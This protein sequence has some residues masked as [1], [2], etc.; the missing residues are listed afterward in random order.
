VPAPAPALDPGYRIDQLG[1]GMP[2]GPED[3]IAMWERERVVHP[4]ASSR[5]VHEVL[6]VCIHSADG[7]VGE[8][9]AYLQ[10]NA[11]LGMDLWYY[12]TYTVREHRM[13]NVGISLALRARDL[14]EDRFV[15]GEDTRGAGLAYEVQNAG[16]RI[17][18]DALWLPL[19]IPFLGVNERG[20]HLR[21]RYFPGARAPGPPR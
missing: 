1:E 13:A 17:Q 7:L 6:L 19:D 11:R 12:R 16:L 5:R 14:L 18:S 10:R 21:V 9:S 20:E 4:A 15:S 3:V 2:V 8:C